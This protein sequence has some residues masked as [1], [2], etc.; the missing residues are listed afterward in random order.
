MARSVRNYNRRKSYGGTSVSCQTSAF[1][2]EM[3]TN[4]GNK[5]DSS[6]EK[7]GVRAAN[8]PKGNVWASVQDHVR[9]DPEV[10]EEGEPCS[11]VIWV[12][13]MGRKCK[14]V[15][16]S[17]AQVTVINKDCFKEYMR[18]K[19]WRPARLKGVAEDNSLS[20]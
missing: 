2:E 13:I 7:E 12:K 9:N 20:S 18:G 6:Q 15:V 14:A 4:L 17:G 5:W 16:D 19:P 11:L 3:Y 8:K 1:Q 10:L